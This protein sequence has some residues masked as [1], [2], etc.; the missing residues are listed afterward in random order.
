MADSVK[1]LTGDGAGIKDFLDKF[2][3]RHFGPPSYYFHM[4]N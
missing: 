4:A 1:Y 3:V 2:D